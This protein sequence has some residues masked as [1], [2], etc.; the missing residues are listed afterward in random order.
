[1]KL[2]LDDWQKEILDCKDRFIL[3]SKGR[4]IG[5]TTTMAQKCGE[6][7][8]SQKG[9]K[10]VIVSLT[11]DQAE[12]VIVMIRD[13]LTINHKKL[14]SRKKWSSTKKLITLTN[15]STAISRP[16]GTTGN[17]VR[18]FTGHVL[19][20]N[21]ASRMQE[22]IFEA[23]KPILLTTSGEIWMDSTHFGTEGFF[24]R[25]WINKKKRWKVFYHSSEEV[26]FNRKIS[27][28]W[29][30][31]QREDAIQFLKDE[32]EEMTILQYRQE[33]MGIAAQDIK[34]VFKDK[35]IKECMILKRRGGI[36]PNR[37]YFIGVD[38]ARMGEDESTFEIF[39]KKEDKHLQHV[40]HQI[41]KHTLTT[42]TTE[43]ILSLNKQYKFKEIF[44]DDGGLGVGVFDQLLE[45]RMK[46]KAIYSESR[47]LTKDEKKRKR[48]I[49]ED[50]FNNLL[51]LMER[52]EIKLLDDPEIFQSLKSVQFEIVNGR[53]KYY[54]NY[55][56]IA[57]GIAFA[58]W[59]SKDKHLNIWVR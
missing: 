2:L 42:E 39:E 20:L 3:L 40:E 17:S 13:F 9:C 58:A 55:T 18:G 34:Q 29:T 35:L 19:Y 21:E 51:M 12:L 54:G 23:A 16:V 33:Y 57:V 41:R 22:L 47:P 45:A 49:K 5:G 8:I 43:H 31:E 37:K 4:Q 27:E 15:G 59:C 6:R 10:I 28:S 32:K 26:I 7:L 1:M 24:Y 44:V 38:V 56:H 53:I 11:E 36:I 46:V 48:A 50:I 30:K 14:I 25:C 52:D